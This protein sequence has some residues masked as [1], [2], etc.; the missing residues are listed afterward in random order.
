LTARQN[1]PTPWEPNTIAPTIIPD[2]HYLAVAAIGLSLPITQ[3]SGKY[4]ENST[5][6]C[7]DMD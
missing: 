7:A 3:C 6:M 4:P 2:A 1:Q 5:L